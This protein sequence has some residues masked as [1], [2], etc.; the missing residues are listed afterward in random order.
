MLYRFLPPLCRGGAAG[1]SIHEVE[2]TLLRLTCV[3]GV[4][5]DADLSDAAFFEE[6]AQMVVGRG[7]RERQVF[8][9][10]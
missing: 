7:A 5:T 9:Q 4:S 2:N 6:L 8:F 3:E 1:L 10:I